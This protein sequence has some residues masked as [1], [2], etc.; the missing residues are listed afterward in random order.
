[1]P[2]ATQTDV[3]VSPPIVAASAVSRK[4]CARLWAMARFL[5][6]S[7][8][9]VVTRDQDLRRW[10][11]TFDDATPVADLVPRQSGTCVGIVKAIRLDPGRRLEVTVQDGS[12]DLV[13]AWPH[14]SVLPGVELG[15]GLRLT[16]TVAED[17]DGSRRMLNPAWTPVAEP[18]S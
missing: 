17:P 10:Q 13:A 18:Y 4:C 7:A 3:R 16:G 6:T 14:R 11:A 12:G 2:R 9:P 1:M 15:S 8:D 5:L